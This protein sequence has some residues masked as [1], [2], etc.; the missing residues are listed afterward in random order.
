MR[1]KI[2]STT[3]LVSFEAAARHESFTK[4]AH[5]LSITQG[6]ICRQIASLEEF[7]SVELFRRSRRG[8]KLTEAGL[9]YSRRVATQLDAVERDTSRGLSR[10]E[11]IQWYLESHEH[12]IDTVQQLHEEQDLIGRVISKMIRD[13]YLVLLPVD[14]ADR[15]APD[16]RRV[17]MVHP[18]VDVDSLQ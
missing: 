5:E 9:S 10:A 4:A 16:E 7:L 17:L 18:Q 11:L 12:E 13:G 15:D 8:V 1:R 6:A 3:A 2:P 14:E